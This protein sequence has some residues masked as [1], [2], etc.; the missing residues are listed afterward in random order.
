[1]SASRKI[2]VI[3]AGAVA[4]GG[5]LLTSGVANAAGFEV[6][7]LNDSGAGSLRQAILDSNALAGADVIT[8]QSGLTGT[9]TLSTGQLSISDSVSLVGPGAASLTIDADRTSRIFYLYN[10]PGL[11]DVTISGLTL[12][13]GQEQEG[14]AILVNDVNLTLQSMVLD[15]NITTPIS[16]GEGGALSADGFNMTLTISD[17]V[18]SGNTATEDGGAIYVEDTGG[19][20]T[21]ERT[22]ISGNT[23]GD[24][25]GGVYFYDPDADVSIIDSTI[26][27]NTASSIGGGVYLYNMDSGVFSIEGSTISGNTATTGGG[28][29]LYDGS[30]TVIVNSTISGNEAT[31]GDGGGIYVYDGAGGADAVTISH[32]TIADNT[33]SG[34]GGNAFFG[35]EVQLS[36]TAIADG[37]ASGSNDVV[38]SVD[39]NANFS[40]IED[41]AGV[42]FSGTSA[43]NIVDTDPALGALAN[44]GGPTQTQLPGVGSV[45]INAGDPAI[46]APPATDQRG[47]ARIVGAAIDIGAVETVPPPTADV[48]ATTE[49]IPLSIVAPGVL[50]NDT[51][52]TSAVL[53]TGP[54]SGSVVLNS[55]GSYVYTPNANFHGGDSFTYE[56]FSGPV[57]LGT[58]TVTLTISPM[59]DP[60]VAVNDVAAVTVGG[61]VTVQVRGND[62]DPDGDTI[63]IVSV[64]Q[65]TKGTV[66]IVGGAVVYRP[67]LNSAGTD[68]F[69]YTIS[70][71]VNV[72]TA[73]VTVTLTPGSIPATGGEHGGEL[74]LAAG[75]VIAGGALTFGSRR[76]RAII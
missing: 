25:G 50:G 52:A 28:V 65:G 5:P 37:T 48:G 18:L 21:I 38:S 30:R 32:T 29:F 36:H 76:R 8:F 51:G 41:S 44:N 71:G 57:S 60:P 26:S 31:S 6:T 72:A 55:D 47:L 62:S 46:A 2:I 3:G 73:S 66:T 1:M 10:N 58:T 23:A 69:T 13:G 7:N 16:G 4:A 67:N 27:G 39:L 63:T 11:I 17:S 45:L 19:P 35:A 64:T 34:G 42:V 9:I 15:D 24:G 53:V 20:L 43:D 14:G 33:A 40:L 54:V 75:L 74:L 22:V 49:D 56:A 61:T 68:T 70:D 59:A 12:T